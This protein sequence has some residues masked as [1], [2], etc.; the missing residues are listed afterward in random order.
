[1]TDS[2]LANNEAFRQ[3]QTEIAGIKNLLMPD[4]FAEIGR[5]VVVFCNVVAGNKAG[6]YRLT[7]SESGEQKAVT[8][9]PKFYGYVDWLRAYRTDP[10]DPDSRKFRLHMKCRSG[11]KYYFEAGWESFFTKTSV[12][13]LAQA[14]PAYLA[15][16]ICITSWVNEIKEGRNSGRHTLG[17]AYSLPQFDYKFPAKWTN[18]SPFGEMLL[19]ADSTIQSVTGRVRQGGLDG[20]E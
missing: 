12:A 10:N 18:E 17:V 2:N 16:P 5:P 14:D 13:F 19:A 4:G 15:H 3:L 11:Q 7:D 20:Y 8:L 6:W 9:P 1:M